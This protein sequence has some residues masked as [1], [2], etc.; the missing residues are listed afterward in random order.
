[1]KLKIKRRKIIL[2]ILILI[3]LILILG[4]ILLILSTRPTTADLATEKLDY[5]ND[6][7]Q[8]N[9]E[10]VYPDYSAA[11]GRAYQGDLTIMD[12]GKSMYYV[13]TEVLPKYYKDLKDASDK[14]IEKYYDKESESICIN[15]A[16]KNKVKFV[17]LIKELQKLSG[18]TITWKSYRIDLD[19]IT[20]GANYTKAV[21]YITYQENKE[22]P[23]NIT[24][25]NTISPNYSTVEYSVDI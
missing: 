22:I 17:N 23:I 18:D 8:W 1:M 3:V 7:E 16:I 2:L 21:L 11:F 20:T 9:D 13:A 10:T 24:A 19:T 6:S 25:N 12:I 14:E 15:L 4:F 5:I